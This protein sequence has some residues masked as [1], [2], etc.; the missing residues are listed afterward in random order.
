[1]TTVLALMLCCLVGLGGVWGAYTIFAL[2][3][4]IEQK[5]DGLVYRVKWLQEVQIAGDVVS[6]YDRMMDRAEEWRRAKP[7][8]KIVAGA[9]R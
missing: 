6:D 2:P 5:I 3:H 4:I 7:R 1:M 8:R 9:R